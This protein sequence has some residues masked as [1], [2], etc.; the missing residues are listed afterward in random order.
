MRTLVIHEMYEVLRRHSATVRFRRGARPDII[1]TTH[2]SP[3]QCVKLPSPCD[4]PFRTFIFHSARNLSRA[5]IHLPCR[6]ER[7]RLLHPPPLRSARRLTVALATPSRHTTRRRR[8][9]CTSLP[10]K[11]SF[12]VEYG[13]PDRDESIR[14]MPLARL[15]R[16]SKRRSKYWPTI[17]YLFPMLRS[18][19]YFDKRADTRS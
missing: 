17:F 14:E 9:D 10:V 11:F 5:Q 1:G 3:P 19:T 8:D 13:S 2:I 18:A 12:P 15:E 6:R 16:Q 7:L 4:S